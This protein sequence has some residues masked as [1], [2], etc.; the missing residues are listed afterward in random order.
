MAGNFKRE[1]KSFP[2]DLYSAEFAF[3]S[4]RNP[5][6]LS[7]FVL[8]QHVQGCA[9]KGIF[10]KKHQNF[11]FEDSFYNVL[12]CIYHENIQKR[13]YMINCFLI[14]WKK[15]ITFCGSTFQDGLLQKISFFFNFF[16]FFFSSIN[17]RNSLSRL[18]MSQ[19][20]SCNCYKRQ[21]FVFDSN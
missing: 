21:W 3:Y 9:R 1:F 6:S 10:Q 12:G 5:R 11:C 4:A 16:F 8:T 14:T 19:K 2:C 15:Y 17:F 18:L 20:H 13:W 7:D